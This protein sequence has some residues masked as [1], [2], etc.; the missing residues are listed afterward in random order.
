M[1]EL[2]RRPSQAREFAQRPQVHGPHTH[3]GRRCG[4]L[5]RSFEASDTD[6][7]MFVPV[8]DRG[9]ESRHGKTTGELDYPET[10]MAASTEGSSPRVIV[11]AEACSTAV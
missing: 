3:G 6:E 1:Y 9:S 4:S 7:P 2:G 11:Y 8:M 10:S 5:A